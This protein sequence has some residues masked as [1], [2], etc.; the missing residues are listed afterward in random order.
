MLPALDD[1]AAGDV[2]WM[3]GTNQNAVAALSSSLIRAALAKHES[4]Q[5]IFPKVQTEISASK[6]YDNN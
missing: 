5:F 3:S 2:S 4:L 6:I 1:P